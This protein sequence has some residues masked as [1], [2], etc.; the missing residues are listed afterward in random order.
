MFREVHYFLNHL[1]IYTILY[2]YIYVYIYIHSI[3]H[4]NCMQPQ[5]H[6]AEVVPDEFLGLVSHTNWCATGAGPGALLDLGWPQAINTYPSM[7]NDFCCSR[8]IRFNIISIFR[9]IMIIMRYLYISMIQ[10]YQYYIVLHYDIYIQ[11][12]RFSSRLVLFRILFFSHRIHH[13]PSI[14]S[15][16]T[17]CRH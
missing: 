6:Q 2:N 12:Y 9:Y 13:N 17:Q 14:Y 4:N 5:K 15:R 7:L 1:Y 8:L 3:S 11:I 16:R 10:I